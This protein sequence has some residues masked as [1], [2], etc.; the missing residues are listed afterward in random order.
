MLKVAKLSEEPEQSLLPLSEE[1]KAPTA[2][3]PRKNKIPSLTQPKSL[4]ASISVEV[5]DNQLT[6]V[7]AI[8]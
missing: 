3:N 7:D 8:E 1:I 2:K 6:A 5:Q 4:K